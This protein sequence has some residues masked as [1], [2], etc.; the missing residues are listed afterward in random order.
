MNTSR[1]RMRRPSAALVLAIVF[2]LVLAAAPFAVGD[3][4]L[5]M[6]ILT[7][8]GAL[9]GMC[10]RL[11]LLT[12]RASLGHGAF[13]AIGAYMFGIATIRWGVPGWAAIPLSALLAGATAY[14]IG[15]PA[16]RSRG[17]YFLLVTFGFAV[18]VH[19]LVVNLKGVTG[20]NSGMPGIP[21]LAGMESINAFYVGMLAIFVVCGALFWLVDRARWTTELKAIGGAP[22]LAEAVGIGARGNMLLALTLGGTI[23][24]ALGGI[25]AS[26]I[27]F[28]APNSFSI[29]FSVYIL[30][31]S[32]I[33]GA[34][35]LLGPVVG[36]AYVT[37]IP[38]LFTWSESHVALFVAASIAL[39]M[40]LLPQGLIPSGHAMLVR[41][42]PSLRSSTEF[43]AED[44]HAGQG[45]DSGVPVQQRVP[46]GTPLLEVRNLNHRFG[47]VRTAKDV[48]LRV[49]AG[50]VVGII[51]PNGAGKTTLF[52]LVSGFL[53]PH[54]GGIWFDGTR[55]ERLAPSRITRLG[56]TRT[57]QAS[58]AFDDLTVFENVLLGVWGSRRSMGLIR[59]YLLPRTFL[60]EDLARA[61][62]VLRIFDLHELADRQARNLSY[63]MRKLLGVAVGFAT[64]PK[65]LCLDEPVAGMTDAEVEQMI[66]TLRRIREQHRVSMLIVEHRMPIIMGLCDRVVVLSFGEVI[67][68]GTPA[69][70]RADPRVHDVYFGH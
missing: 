39:A 45:A 32:V 24:G 40:L 35:F 42:F 49:G 25:Y 12:G 33:G 9:L 17:P 41:L 13:V 51:G 26:Y 52:N 53:K 68:E 29:W 69:E 5:H 37:L 28:I 59:R 70:V 20:G 50:E 19:S 14:L 60:K 21:K 38:L 36:A 34:A 8:F 7:F 58:M 1:N 55:I 56:L 57:F 62:E 18:V 11:L 65:L 3:Y 48:N 15:L 22:D 10:H 66:S 27:G 63:G 6:L 44:G 61:R 46:A 16:L 31:Y 43:G 4:Y 54:S 2:C 64:N 47:G 30:T 67:A 23:A